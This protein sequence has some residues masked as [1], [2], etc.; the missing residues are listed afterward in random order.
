MPK[1]DFVFTLTS[2]FTC[3]SS[4]LTLYISPPTSKEFNNCM[5]VTSWFYAQNK[6]FWLQNLFH[7]VL[8]NPINPKKKK[9]AV[10]VKDMVGGGSG[11]GMIAVK[12][13]MCIFRAS[14]IIYVYYMLH[15]ETDGNLL[16]ERKATLQW[17]RWKWIESWQMIHEK[18]QFVI[19]LNSL[20]IPRLITNLLHLYQA[21]DLLPLYFK[22]C[23]ILAFV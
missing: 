11:L 13:S 18:Q 4:Y 20:F 6:A 16:R 17:Q 7:V 21:P 19:N 3:F 22:S 23:V 2:I 8:N 10:A 12:D 15:C 14:L 5:T 1:T 9:L